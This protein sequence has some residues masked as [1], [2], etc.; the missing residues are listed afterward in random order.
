M[1]RP[2]LATRTLGRDGPDVGAIGLGVAPMSGLYGQASEEEGVRAIHVALDLGMNLLDTA[3]VY[4]SGHNERLLGK[5]IRDR[6]DEAIVST[7]F[8][9]VVDANGRPSR[10]SGRAEYVHEACTRSLRRLGVDVIDL[11]LQ[12][13]V[14]PDTPIEETVGAMGELVQ[15]GKVRYV[16]LCEALPADLRRAAA[17]HPI[18]VLQSE[19]S[20]FERGVEAEVLDT[21]EELGIGFMA[22][23][24]LSRGLLGGGLD[25]ARQPDPADTRKDGTRY[26]RLGPEHLAANLELAQTVRRIAAQ[27]DAGPAEVALAWLLARRPWI[28]PIPGTRREAHVRSNALAAGLAL[29]E[30]DTAELDDLASNVAGARFGRDVPTPDWLSPMSRSP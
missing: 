2:V 26:P 5:A 11:Y 18:A 15:A 14:D 27:H 17:V 12:H 6:R 28:V 19:Y 16:G 7:K 8:G 23:S 22:Y 24:P 21:C 20:V 29:T 4:G 9:N 3:D 13:R 10:I 1:Q 30:D 25:P